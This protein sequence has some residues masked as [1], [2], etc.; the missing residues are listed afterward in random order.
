MATAKY[1]QLIGLITIIVLSV[2][3]GVKHDQNS[4]EEPSYPFRSDGQRFPWNK[5]RLP[6]TILPV[7][8]E[9][10]LHPNLTTLNFSASVRIEVSIGMDTNSII[11]HSKQLDIIKATIALLR[12]G[13]STEPESN[14]RLLEYPSY[15]QIALLSDGLLYSGNTY[16]INIDY[17]GNLSDS[18]HGFYKGSYKTQDGELRVLASTQFEPTAAHMAFPCFDEPAFK[19]KFTIKIQRE[20]RHITLS[21]MPIII[22]SKERPSFHTVKST[23]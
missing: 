3:D 15:D 8:Y 12:E 17:I 21:N 6:D 2:A 1:L 5:M 7:H 13:G 9:L 10:L 11:L 18:Y 23:N 16:L 19:A 4:G 20:S 14:L 22:W